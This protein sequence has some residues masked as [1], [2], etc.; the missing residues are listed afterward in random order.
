MSRDPK[1][2][3]VSISQ[4]RNSIRTERLWYGKIVFTNGCFDLLHAGHVQYLYEA[5]R[6]GDMLIVGINSDRSVRQSKGENRPIV[7]AEQRAYAVAALEC[8]SFVI[9][10]DEDTPHK[11]LEAIRP[12]F[13]IKGGDYSVDEVVGKEIVEGYGGRVV[14]MS[15]VEGLS[16]SKIIRRIRRSLANDSSE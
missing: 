4:L 3:I 8:V 10:F 12:D 1:E 6:C 5:R 7:P 14:V 11:L 13:L 16:S 9:I 2:K 15:H